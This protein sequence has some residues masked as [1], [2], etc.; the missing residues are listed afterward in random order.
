M[1]LAA[2]EPATQPWRYT[3]PPPARS[4]PKTNIA[5]A[6]DQQLVVLV[7]AAQALRL[8]GAPQKTNPRRQ[9]RWPFSPW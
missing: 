5:A 1:A 2:A 6:P 9:R 4:A 3:P 7:K 8:N